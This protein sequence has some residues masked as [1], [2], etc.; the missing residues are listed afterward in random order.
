MKRNN[1]AIK[2]TNI[3]KK[4]ILHHE[5]PTL[6]ENLFKKEE[7]FWALKKIG[8]EVKKGDRVGIIGPNGAGKSTLLKIVAGITT[9]TTGKV[10]IN[11]RIASLIDLRAGFHPDLTGEENIYINGL[12]L[13]MNLK[14]LKVKFNQIVEFS[15][16]EKFIDAPLYTYSSG[17]MLR[18]G[19]SVVIHT[20]PDILLV[21]EVMS[22]GDLSFRTKSYERIKAMLSEG[23]TFV[24]VTHNL[25]RVKEFCQKVYLIENGMISKVGKPNEIVKT[26]QQQKRH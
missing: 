9:P 11:G 22:A 20:E 6:V 8:L 15:E 21:D 3:S 10:A 14:E 19:F 2:L 7:E 26:Y 17:M 16:L 23:A 1:F 4:Y 25:E 12:L 13:G 5:K 18:L 24:F